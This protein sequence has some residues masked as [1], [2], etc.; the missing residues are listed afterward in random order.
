MGGEGLVVVHLV[1]QVLHVQ[2][3]VDVFGQLVGRHGVVAHVAVDHGGVGHAAVHV[4]HV[5][6]TTT[7]GQLRR[8]GVG[9]PQ[10]G[11]VVRRVRQ[12]VAV[13]GLVQR[14]AVDLASFHVGVAGE[15][16]PLVGELAAGR[17][18]DTLH[19]GFAD[20]FVGGGVHLHT[21][22]FLLGAEQRGG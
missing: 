12:L 5:E 2:L 21:R 7:D 1:G 20:V 15:Y 16:L 19:A 9:G 10:A 13:V 6:G 17:Q 3:Q 4:I 11:A 18:F 8:N 14:A 22:I